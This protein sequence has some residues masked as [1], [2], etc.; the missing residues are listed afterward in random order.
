ML[1]QQLLAVGNGDGVNTRKLIT[2][3]TVLHV[4]VMMERLAVIRVLPTHGAGIEMADNAAPFD[5]VVGELWDR[6]RTIRP[7]CDVVGRGERFR[8]SIEYNT[9]TP[10]G[11]EWGS[12]C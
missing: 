5:S 7:G 8:R 6:A 3:T 1:V 12:G 9:A 10:S 4:V 2:R 11:S